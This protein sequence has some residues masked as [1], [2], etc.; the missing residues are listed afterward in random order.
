MATVTGKYAACALLLLGLAATAFGQNGRRTVMIVC[1]KP[2]ALLPDL[3]LV[4]QLQQRLALDA[5]LTIVIPDQSRVPAPGHPSF[6][7][8]TLL[9]RGREAGCRYLLYLK[10]D[11]G[12]IATRKQTS[13]PFILS[14]YVV[15]GKLTGRYL[16]LDIDKGRQMGQ[17]K[18]KTC[19]VGNRRWQAADDYPDDPDLFLSAPRKIALLKQVE[20]RAADEIMLAIQP[21]MKGR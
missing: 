8:D 5:G 4:E 11:D 14:R 12:G 20:E 6:D 3:S 18:L 16:L 17:W 19:S 10:I 7:I 13:I 21:Y 2:A 15:E 1:D 9:A